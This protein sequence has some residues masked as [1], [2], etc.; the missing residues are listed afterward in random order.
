[1]AAPIVRTEKICKDFGPIRV[2]FDIDFHVVPGE[3]HAVIGENGA[4]KSTLVKLLAGYHD[5]TAGKILVK[6]K[7]VRFLSTKDAEDAGISM[8]HQ[9][10]NLANDLTVEEN[11]FLGKERNRGWFLDRR[12]MQADSRDVL[13]SLET[14]VSPT[15]R[16]KDLSVSQ[17][18][19]VEIAKA[20]S[21][22]ADV[23]IMDEPTAVLTR[24][25]IKVL[26]RLI[27]QLQA[28]GVAII[29]ISHKLDEVK[30]IADTVTVLRDGLLVDSQPVDAIT[31]D[32]MA[33]KMVGRELSD[34]FPSK[35]LIPVHEPVLQAVGISSPGA[36]ADCS[37]SLYQQEVL[38]FAGLVGAGRTELMETIAGLRHRSAGSLAIRGRPVS[39]NDYRDAVKNRLVYLSEDRKGKGLLVTKPMPFNLTLL[40]LNRYVRGIGIIDEKQELEA[41][42]RAVKDFEIRAPSTA[43]VIA[44]LSGGN[45]QKVAFAK[46]LEVDPDI[47]ILDEPTR[48][49]DVGTKRQI[50]ALIHDLAAAGKSI[51]VISSE[52]PEI[53][54][55][56]SRAVVMRQGRIA[57][58]VS[59]DDVN[60]EEIMR[61][62]MGLKGGNNDVEQNAAAGKT[63]PV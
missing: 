59:G 63:S 56:C 19:M 12:Q 26:F 39:V 27:R 38:G 7:P 41:M 14:D 22:R 61:Y 3:V 46:I 1:M 57:G 55:L 42:E 23:L 30:E 17:K 43:A 25:E 24:S 54:G 16:V 49:I 20:V 37:F 36:A 2:L 34:M 50:Y 48:G 44:T 15:A 33:T 8:I 5:P 53:I 4:G 32:E 62:A 9:E 13:A 18:Q 45:Q 29:Y 60:E 21:R 51:I 10:F 58:E 40:A 47:L 52:L 6:G 28:G 11:I 35:Q 31:E